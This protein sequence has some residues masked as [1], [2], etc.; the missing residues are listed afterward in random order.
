MNKI[1]RAIKKGNLIQK[2]RLKLLTKFSGKKM[3][4]EKFCKK[5]GK[6]A[7]NYK[8]NLESPKTFN[9]KINWIKLHDRKDE[10]TKMVDKY[11]VKP[12]VAELIGD[13]K[14]VENYGVWDDFDSI[15]FDALPQSFVLKCTHDSGGIFIVR[16]KNNFDKAKAKKLLEEHL[17]IN[18]YN[19]GREW[20][21]KNVKPRILAEKYLEEF[22]SKSIV[23]YKFFCCNGK[24]SF[25]YISRGLEDHTTAQ[26]SF[27]D[28]NGEK[29]PFKRSDYAPID[30]IDIPTNFDEMKEVASKLASSIDCKF[31]RVDLYS[32]NNKIYFSELTFSPC[33]GFIPF[34]PIEADLEVG[35][36]LKL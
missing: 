3:S 5:Y 28:L 12:F 18:F 24:A 16:D 34:D 11:D 23:D 21:Y 20:P 10:Y 14:I 30:H 15:D 36:Y 35:K 2:I 33:G 22:S 4:D 31:V 25:L 7:L 13:D 26:I 27:F 32:I 6:V 8:L 1:L 29:L 17:K 9:E 19:V